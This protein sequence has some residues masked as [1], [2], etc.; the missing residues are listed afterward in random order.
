MLVNKLARRFDT[1]GQSSQFRLELNMRRCHKNE[2]LQS[3]QQD[4]SRL[5]ALAYEGPRSV[6][7][8]S[9]AVEAFLKALD[10][11]DLSIR[12]K[13][14]EPIDIDHA[15]RHAKRFESYTQGTRTV[16][17]DDRP[18]FRETNARVISSQ[19]SGASSI[20]VGQSNAQSSDIKYAEM[21]LEVQRMRSE[22]DALKSDPKTVPVP[23]GQQMAASQSSGFTPSYFTPNQR[24][25][26]MT[27]QWNGPD[28]NPAG[29][30]RSD[31]TTERPVSNGSNSRGCFNCHDPS[32]YKRDCPH[33]S[34]EDRQACRNRFQENTR[35]NVRSG[36]ASMHGQSKAS[37]VYLR[38]SLNGKEQ[39]CLLD[40]GCEMSVLP[41]RLSHSLKIK[42]TKQKLYAA[43]GSRIP[44]RGQTQIEL[45]LDGRPLYVTV[46]IS[47]RIS[48]PMLVIDF[49][50][51]N[52]IQW[53]F[54]RGIVQL[55]RIHIH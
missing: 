50:T 28:N 15:V 46:L 25:Y 27:P 39:E 16:R 54:G 45:N 4:I 51:E 1:D 48:E 33:L 9:F 13:E 49:L 31:F 30:F 21:A 17:N 41:L 8:D 40:T 2:S 20:A 32:H 37:P 19:N 55:G 3:L 5:M 18:M 38:L 23:A 43:N 26:D 42:S 14:L 6:H 12:V 53:D 24:S 34:E 36:G 11:P 35:R 7:T 47:S 44:L 29:N 22:L 10:D 52:N